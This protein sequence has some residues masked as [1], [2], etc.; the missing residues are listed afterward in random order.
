[1]D[2]LFVADGMGLG[3]QWLIK[4]GRTSVSVGRVHHDTVR[5]I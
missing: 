5:L 3:L 1:M 4:S 2:V